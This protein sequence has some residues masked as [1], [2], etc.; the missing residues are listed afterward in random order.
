MDRNA[1]IMIHHVSIGWGREKVQEIE[2]KAAQARL[3]NDRV[4]RMM[5]RNC[6]QPETYFIDL[7]EKHK[8]NAD[9]YLSSEECLTHRLASKLRVPKLKTSVRV[10]ISFE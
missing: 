4:Y 8:G 1:T 10:E 6:D 3:L 9:W 7:V 2:S 5:A